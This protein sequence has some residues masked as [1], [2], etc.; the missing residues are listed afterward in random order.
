V[1]I[2]REIYGEASER[3]G[4]RVF[5]ERRYTERSLADRLIR[6]AWTVE[7]REYVR[8]AHDVHGRFYALRPW[9]FA[10]GGA[11]RFVCP[12]NFR[13]IATPAALRPGEYGVAYLRL[14]KPGGR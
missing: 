12:G 1:W 2:D 11:L 8:Q 5:F 3:V 10:A 7:E 6:D 9:S 13:A 4:E 14:R